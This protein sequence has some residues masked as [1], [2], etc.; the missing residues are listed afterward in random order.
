MTLLDFIKMIDSEDELINVLNDEGDDMFTFWSGSYFTDDLTT[1][2][3]HKLKTLEVKSF[4]LQD[5]AIM[6][7]GECCGNIAIVVTVKT[8]EHV[9]TSVIGD[10]L[11]NIYGEEFY[12]ELKK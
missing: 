11:K 10:A 5:D 7:P 6:N 12:S 1:E 2:Q 9:D 4:H 3:V 8:P